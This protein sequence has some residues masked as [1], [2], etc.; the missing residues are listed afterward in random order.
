MKKEE[1]KTIGWAA[2]AAIAFWFI[3]SFT[4]IIQG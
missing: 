1:L 2:I 4:A 3:M